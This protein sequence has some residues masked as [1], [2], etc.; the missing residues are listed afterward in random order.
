VGGARVP[1]LKHVAI[2]C[3]LFL[4]GTLA[5]YLA[6]P[7]VEPFVNGTMNA[8]AAARLI[9]LVAP[10]A[11]VR[12]VGCRIGSGSTYLLIA[13]GCEGV[14]VMIMLAAAIVAFPMTWRKKVLG[15]VTGA[16]LIYVVNLSRTVGLWFCL[17]YW[18]SAFDSMHTT[19]GQTVL[20]VVGA[21]FFAAW[22]G[23]LGRAR[24]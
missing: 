21:L 3:A 5:H 14:D 12:A 22:T 19:V 23:A 2:F 13:P 17:R 24:G 20:I 4:T 1:A 15:A 10:A 18:P 16:L 9:D 6:R 7:Y 11:G 8:A